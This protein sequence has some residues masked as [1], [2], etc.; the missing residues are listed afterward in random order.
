MTPQLL[1]EWITVLVRDLI[2][3]VLG[4]FLTYRGYTEG[5]LLP[6][7]LPLLAGMMSIPLV[8][9]LPRRAAPDHRPPP[10]PPAEL[11]E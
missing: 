11:P 4:A 9:H 2:I 3:P 7:H 8:A 1:R 10:D 6:W 5:S